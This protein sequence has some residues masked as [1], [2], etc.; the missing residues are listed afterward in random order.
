MFGERTETISPV[1]LTLGV[2]HPDDFGKW[3]SVLRGIET[4]DNPL[5]HTHS[6]VGVPEE[7][8][9]WLAPPRAGIGPSISAS[10]SW[11]S[12]QKQ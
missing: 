6:L 7:H 1:G 11:W 2:I 4:I 3:G 5:P 10:R 9:R 8:A 12:W